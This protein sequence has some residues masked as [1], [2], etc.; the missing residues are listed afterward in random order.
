MKSEGSYTRDNAK[1]EITF[2]LR[3]TF[4]LTDEPVRE[5]QL[6]T[7]MRKMLLVAGI[8]MENAKA[9]DARV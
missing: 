1:H 9:R 7:L 6:T 2:K 4:E 3:V 5:V 8:D